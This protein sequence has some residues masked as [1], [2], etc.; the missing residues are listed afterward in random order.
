MGFGTYNLM[1]F[2]M[3]LMNC[4][5]CL[6]LVNFATVPIKQI[7]RDVIFGKWSKMV[8]FYP[9]VLT[10]L[11]NFIQKPKTQNPVIKYADKHM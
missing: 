2:Y 1:K 5:N 9:D 4:L 10:A 3:D 6:G 8:K 7:A 11:M